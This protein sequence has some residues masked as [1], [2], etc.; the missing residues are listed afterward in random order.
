[1]KNKKISIL[2]LS[3]IILNEIIVFPLTADAKTNRYTAKRRRAASASKLAA[4]ST[5]AIYTT[6]D[7]VVPVVPENVVATPEPATLVSTN[8]VVNA[9][10]TITTTQTYSDGSV[11][12]SVTNADGTAL[13]TEQQLTMENNALKSEL[14]SSKALNALKTKFAAKLTEASSACSGIADDLAVIRGWATATTV[15]SGLGTMAAGGAL[16]VSLVKGSVD[17]RIENSQE[18]ALV[19]D[20]L[21]Q[22]KIDEVKG[23]V[24]EAWFAFDEAKNAEDNEKM[25]EE[26]KKIDEL[27]GQYFKEV[28]KVDLNPFEEGPSVNANILRQQ[29]DALQKLEPYSSIS[30]TEELSGKL[31]S[32][33][34][35]KDNETTLQAKVDEVNARNNL[36]NSKDE[37]TSKTLGNIRTGLMAGATATSTVSTVSS[38]VSTG[39]AKTLVKRM[40]TCNAKIAELKQ[41][42]A[43]FEAEE[44]SIE[45]ATYKLAS[46]IAEKCSPFDEKN[47][48]KVSNVMLASGIISSVGT[49][50]A[51]AGTVTSIMANNDKVRSDDSEKGKKKEKNLNLATTILAGV[52]TGTSGASTALSVVAISKVEK[53]ADMAKDCLDALNSAQ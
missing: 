18:I 45:D 37:Q 36:K 51:G 44:M 5:T 19:K 7:T 47:I 6:T 48:E 15:S 11:S 43:E 4:S 20:E 29:Y 9:D 16:A 22:E 30:N 38:F 32:Y 49:A 39:R 24:G 10:G 41:I 50:T 3:A 27:Y 46:N 13:S 17:K 42:K 12:S 35:E 14:K 40:A 8:T 25:I 34:A 1:M 52:T 2:T 21:T 28:G 26:A 31:A 23:V 33:D 53:D